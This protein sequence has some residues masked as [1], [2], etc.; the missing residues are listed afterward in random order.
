MVQPSRRTTVTISIAFCTCPRDP[1]SHHDRLHS[2]FNGDWDM[3]AA[4]LQ[5]CSSL[6]AIGWAGPRLRGTLFPSVDMRIRDPMTA[7]RVNIGERSGQHERC[8]GTTSS[9]RCA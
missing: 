6:L 9:A 4:I 1:S 3:W 7:P 5:E 2:L 8:S